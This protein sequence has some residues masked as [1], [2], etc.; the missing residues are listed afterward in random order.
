MLDG[1][2]RDNIK[3]G[4]IVKI[5][6]KKDRGTGR[7][8]EGIVKDVLT[9]LNSHPQ[10]ILVQLENGSVG[11]VKE[12]VES[13]LVKTEIET[14]NPLSNKPREGQKL[15][16]KSS[17]RFDWK[18]FR[19][20]NEKKPSEDVEMTISKTI[21][22]FANADGGKLYIGV[23]DDDGHTI[24]GLEE[25]YTLLSKA[26]SDRFEIELKNSIKKFCKNKYVLHN[27]RCNF[28]N[29]GNKEVCEITIT[30]SQK[31][32]IVYYGNRPI[33]YVRIGNSSEEQEPEDF[34]DY[35]MKHS[36]MLSY[37]EY[38]RGS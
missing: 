28:F 31:P 20:T 25:D 11:R 8:T 2:I 38:G 18:R 6:E 32:V 23:D 15:E 3:P 19:N 27:I 26:G 16:Y 24:L 34:I 36:E 9:D 12:I 21:A 37:G 35:W 5:E 7:L 33:F 13:K 1:T 22:A 4:I 30:P 17:F 29:V 10:G 14:Y